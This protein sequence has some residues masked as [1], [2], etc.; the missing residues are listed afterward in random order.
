MRNHIILFILFFLSFTSIFAQD[1]FYPEQH[2]LIQLKNPW[3][4]SNNAA[5]LTILVIPLHGNTELGY[6]DAGGDYHRAQEGNRLNGLRFVSERYDKI[7]KNWLSWGS[8]EFQMNKEK[9][10]NWS[11]VF[12]TYNS[13]PYIFGDSIKGNYDTQFFDLH[14]KLSRKI[15]NQFS[16]GIGIDYYAADMSRYINYLQIRLLD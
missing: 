5:G 2:E 13:S 16:L 14:A 6:N 4:N 7:G 8:F 1:I 15:N 12:N 3:L 10:R 9:E 11:N